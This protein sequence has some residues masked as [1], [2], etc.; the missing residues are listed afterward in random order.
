MSQTIW[1][2]IESLIQSHGG[3]QTIDQQSVTVW[4]LMLQKSKFANSWLG[5]RKI[6]IF[7]LNLGAIGFEIVLFFFDL[8]ET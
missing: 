7:G 5:T 8:M 2:C 6:K 4:K 1:I 3:G